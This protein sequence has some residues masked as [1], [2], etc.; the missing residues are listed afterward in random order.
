MHIAHRI[1]SCAFAVSKSKSQGRS[2]GTAPKRPQTHCRMTRERERGRW[3]PTHAHTDSL[4]DKF[5]DGAG[6]GRLLLLHSEEQGVGFSEHSVELAVTL[7]VLV[8][9]FSK[10]CN[11]DGT[12]SIS[13]DTLGNHAL[14]AERIAR[15]AQDTSKEDTPPPLHPE[16]RA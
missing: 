3:T 14:S 2:S 6:Q 12:A 8:V 5:P 13:L 15:T 4:S 11:P 10:H 16:G 7:T 1:F 9:A